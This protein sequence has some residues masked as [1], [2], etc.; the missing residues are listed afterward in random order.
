MISKELRI[1]IKWLRIKR[2]LTKREAQAAVD[3]DNF[4]EFLIKAY[5]EL[6][7]WEKWTA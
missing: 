6:T 1:V 7:W 2:G 5:N 3:K 4:T